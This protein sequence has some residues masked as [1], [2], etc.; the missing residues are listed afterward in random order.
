[1]SFHFLYGFGKQNYEGRAFLPF[2]S[3]PTTFKRSTTLPEFLGGIVTSLAESLCAGLT[4]LKY[5]IGHF[6]RRNGITGC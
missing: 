4:H 1:M 2:A 5:Q 3:F 6:R